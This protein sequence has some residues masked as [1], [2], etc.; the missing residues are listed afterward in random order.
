MQKNSQ[1]RPLMRFSV[2][3]FFKKQPLNC[4]E[5]KSIEP[6]LVVEDI[7]SSSHPFPQLTSGLEVGF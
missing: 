2:L 6:T 7:L 5:S 1:V 3:A 4:L